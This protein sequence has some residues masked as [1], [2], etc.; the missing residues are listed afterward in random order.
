MLKL[1]GTKYFYLILCPIFIM[2]INIKQRRGSRWYR[3]LFNPDSHI[4]TKTKNKK[5]LKKILR[6]GAKLQI[7][8]LK[9]VKINTTWLDSGSKGHNI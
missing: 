6:K 1:G 9:R 8:K 5:K 4:K 2:L 7:S 3:I